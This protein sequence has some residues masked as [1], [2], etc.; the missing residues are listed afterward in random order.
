MFTTEYDWEPDVQDGFWGT[1]EVHFQAEPYSP[2]QTHGPSDSWC[3]AEGGVIDI[4]SVELVALTA[5]FVDGKE[6]DPPKITDEIRDQ[7]KAAFDLAISQDDKLKR[8]V[9]EV[10]QNSLPDDEDY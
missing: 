5:H 4:C 9:T 3:P 10:C 8:Q 7:M 2:A 1:F 6:F